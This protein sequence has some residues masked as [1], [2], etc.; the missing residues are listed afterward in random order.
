MNKEKELINLYSQ[1]SDQYFHYVRLLTNELNET[2]VIANTH[3]WKSTRYKEGCEFRK[4]IKD[5]QLQISQTSSRKYGEVEF[6]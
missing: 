3:G 4:K 6:V 2:V 1:L 5:L